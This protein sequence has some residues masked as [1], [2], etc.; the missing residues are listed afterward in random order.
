M[1]SIYQLKPAFQSLLRPI[2]N[3]LARANI[4]PN[5]VTCFALCASALSGCW[6]YFSEA[7]KYS[8]LF[9]PL[10]LFIRM[11]LNA[12]DGM[13]AREHNKQSASGALLN[14]IGDVLSDTFIYLPFVVIPNISSELV[15]SAVILG[16]ISEIAGTITVQIGASRRFDGPMGKSDRAFIFGLIALLIGCDISAGI[17]LTILLIVVNL[18]LGITIFNRLSKALK[19]IDASNS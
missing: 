19:E 3:R 16:L 14:E 1:P 6:L 10:F 13:L 17:W 8:L 9:L 12:I 2:V 7:S 5:Q 15:V 11:A 4:S 18:L